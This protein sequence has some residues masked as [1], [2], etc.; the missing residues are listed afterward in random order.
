MYAPPHARVSREQYQYDWRRMST[1]IA[2]HQPRQASGTTPK[3]CPTCGLF[4]SQLSYMR[5]SDLRMF[6]PEYHTLSE[7]RLLKAYQ[8]EQIAEYGRVMTY[9]RVVDWARTTRHTTVGVVGRN[10]AHPFRRYLNEVYPD[11]Q[12]WHARWTF[13][14]SACDALKDFQQVSHSTGL[15][16]FRNIAIQESQVSFT[17]YCPLPTWAQRMV[18]HLQSL[19]FNTPI[20]REHLLTTLRVTHLGY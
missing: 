15:F 3:R 4:R 5:A 14:P 18:A 11:F 16:L 19:P 2:A 10:D 8:Q 20:S 13:Y 12:S 6:L 1:M 17:M 9:D 7:T